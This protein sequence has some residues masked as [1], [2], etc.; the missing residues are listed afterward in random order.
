ME[1]QDT[2][3]P[4]EAVTPENIDGMGSLLF[5]WFGKVFL[6]INFRQ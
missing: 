2:P 4:P 3:A 6:K 1:E 5:G